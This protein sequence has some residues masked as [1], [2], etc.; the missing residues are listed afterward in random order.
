MV[1]VRL[2][3]GKVIDVLEPEAVAM[4]ASGQAVPVDSVAVETAMLD[5]SQGS[6]RRL[7]NVELSD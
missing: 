4:I 7:K 3:T 1:R 6:E 2:K 5:V